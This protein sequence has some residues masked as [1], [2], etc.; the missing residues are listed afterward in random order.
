MELRY[1]T[2]ENVKQFNSRCINF[3]A[4]GL[5]ALCPE[6]VPVG[7]M[8]NVI[9]NL[10][11]TEKSL[12]LHGHVKWSM[13]R[14]R[15]ESISQD[16]QFFIGV[17]FENVSKSDIKEL[18]DATSQP[19]FMKYITQDSRVQE[20]RQV[21]VDFNRRKFNRREKVFLHEET[22]YLFDTNAVGNTYYAQHFI[23]QGKIREAFLFYILDSF[24]E[25]AKSGIKLITKE[26]SCEYFHESHLFETVV[27]ML[28]VANVT[29]TRVELLTFKNKNTGTIISKD[30]QVI[31]FAG[32]MGRPIAIPEPILKGLNK[33]RPS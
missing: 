20:R 22:I 1:N 15:T 12:S 27:M 23:W 18:Q 16:L 2:S 32:P 24:E 17:Q 6:S 3:T 4:E 7:T 30:R 8:V 14:E 10:P 25:F 9:L 19:P 29:R 26:A 28:K 13:L 11:G 33:F 31:V 21:I 5:T